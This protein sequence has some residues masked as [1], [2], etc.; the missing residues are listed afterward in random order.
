[1]SPCVAERRPASCPGTA[2]A[3][4]AA[5]TLRKSRRDGPPCVDEGCLDNRGLAVVMES[6]AN[7]KRTSCACRRQSTR[8]S[9]SVRRLA[10]H[11]LST[12]RQSPRSLHLETDAEVQPK[13]NRRL[14]LA[15]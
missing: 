8:L 6:Y 4:P 14:A 10:I 11:C 7:P 1:M 13:P 2:A 12:R 9:S 3:S 15:P 5:P